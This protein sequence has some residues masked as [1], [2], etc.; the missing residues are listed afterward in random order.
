MSD[1]YLFGVPGLGMVFVSLLAVMV[2]RGVSRAEFKWFWA[3]A[4]LWTVA[5]VSKVVFALLANQAAATFLH[6][7]LPPL[8]LLP[9]TGLYV[10]AI[11]AAFEI[12]LTWLAGR[13]WRFLGRD[14]SK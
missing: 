9:V 6:R 1:F 3:G 5:V 13:R 12:G 2:W 8:L 11:S 4:A 10:G 14:R 7:V